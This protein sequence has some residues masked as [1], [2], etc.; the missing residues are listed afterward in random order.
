MDGSSQG[1]T[2][3]NTHSSHVYLHLHTQTR[4][5]LEYQFSHSQIKPLRF[6]QRPAELQIKSL[7]YSFSLPASEANFI[8]CCHFRLALLQP[9]RVH[10]PLPP[11]PASLVKLYKLGI[12]RHA[13]GA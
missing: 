6:P 13:L 5:A 8:G 2:H 11:S 7:F 4:R 10:S 1:G 12:L 9:L 3:V